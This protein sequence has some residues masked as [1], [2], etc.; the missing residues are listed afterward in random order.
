MIPHHLAFTL[1]CF[2]VKSFNTYV[3]IIL[4]VAKSQTLLSMKL[5]KVLCIKKWQQEAENLSLTESRVSKILERKRVS[6]RPSWSKPGGQVNWI[7]LD[8][9]F[10]QVMDYCTLVILFNASFCRFIHSSFIECIV[11]LMTSAYIWLSHE[12]Q[13]RYKELVTYFKMYPVTCT[14]N[15]VYYI[16][17][18]SYLLSLRICQV[19]YIPI[20]FTF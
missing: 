4:G 1:F 8:E 3:Y 6:I 2:S 18:F 20:H 12:S 7:C 14:C 11:H 10:Q 9:V 5:H 17:R 13:C 19:T 16:S 15:T